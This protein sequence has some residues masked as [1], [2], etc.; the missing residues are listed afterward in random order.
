MTPKQVQ[1]HPVALTF[2]LCR[3]MERFFFFQFLFSWRLSLL[4]QLLV[5][6][7]IHST[8][9]CYVFTQISASHHLVTIQVNKTQFIHHASSLKIMLLTLSAELWLHDITQFF[10]ARVI[11][12]VL[13]SWDSTGKWICF[14]TAWWHTGCCWR[15]VVCM[16]FLLYWFWGNICFGYCR[17]VDSSKTKL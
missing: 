3:Y 7:F 10:L 2:I 17:D 9:V 5:S 6:T 14:H 11:S 1:F 8:L 15:H 13:H 12:L 16:L 4:N